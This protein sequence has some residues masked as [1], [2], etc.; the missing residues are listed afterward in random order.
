MSKLKPKVLAAHFPKTVS[1]NQNSLYGS[2]LHSLYFFQWT[3]MQYVIES[4]S[5][6]KYKCSSS[7][8]VNQDILSK[9]N[10]C[11]MGSTQIES[12]SDC[13]HTRLYIGNIPNLQCVTLCGIIYYRGDLTKPPFRPG[14]PTF[15][16]DT[17][18]GFHGRCGMEWE[19]EIE[20]VASTRSTNEKLHMFNRDMIITFDFHFSIR[21]RTLLKMTKPVSRRF[22][23]QVCQEWSWGCVILFLFLFLFWLLQSYTH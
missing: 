12:L 15:C 3:G 1:W 21:Y 9:W 22:G 5:W 4:S 16:S 2:H 20:Y 11:S 6:Q 14:R 8:K 10:I 18:V 7:C 17:V 13:L 23:D 19:S